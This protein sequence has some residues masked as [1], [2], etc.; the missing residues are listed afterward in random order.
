MC[1]K[2]VVCDADLIFWN[3]VVQW[4]GSVHDARILR[5]S[6]LFEQFEGANRPLTGLLVGDSGYMLREWL[7]TPLPNPNT[8]AEQD[9]YHHS[10]ARSAVER[11][12]GVLK[13]RWTEPIT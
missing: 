6:D 7:M 13:K 3:C 12:I 10:L 1:P 8:R 5:E 11:A 9:N 2:Q 4:P